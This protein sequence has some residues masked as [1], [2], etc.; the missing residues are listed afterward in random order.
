MWGAAQRLIERERAGKTTTIIHLGDHDPSGMDMTRDIQDRLEL[1]GSSALVKRIALLTEQV[2]EYD[3]P[4]G[5]V[6]WRI[7]PDQ[8]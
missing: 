3:P 8:A 2:E 5:V 4:P 6:W 1:F 7:G